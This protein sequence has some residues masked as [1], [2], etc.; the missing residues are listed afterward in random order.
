MSRLRPTSWIALIALGLVA[1]GCPRPAPEPLTGNQPPPPPSADP[2]RD[3]PTLAAPTPYLAPPTTVFE[4]SE[5]L[6]VWLVERPSLPIVALSLSVPVGSAQDPPGKGGLCHITTAM[7]DEGAGDRDAIDIS[8]EINDLGAELGAQ[9]SLDGSQVTLTVLRKH[10]ARAF[11]IFSDVVIRP[12]FDAAEYKRVSGLWLDG[13]R[14]RSDEPT[15]VARLVRAAALYGPD[16]PYGHP[17]DGYLDTAQAIDVGD[18]K[19]FH[20]ASWRPDRALL[21]AAGAVTRAELERLIAEHLGSWTKPS[22]PLP[23]SAPPPTPLQ[24]RPRLVLVDRQDAPQAV[25]SVTRPGVAAAQPDAA[26]LEL[27]NTALG[28]SFTSRLNQNL[29]ED[30]AWSYGAR[31]AFVETRG[32]GPFVAQSS[33]FTNVTAAALREMLSEIDRMA[34]SGLTE[35]E[36]RKV[37]ARD[38]T[39]TIETHETVD[40]LVSRLT[41]LGILGLPPDHDSR[42]SRVRQKA[43]LRDLARLASRYLSTK[44]ATIVVVGPAEQLLP[45]LRALDV[46][47]VER[48]SPEGRP[49]RE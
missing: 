21:V 26:L 15:T 42:A 18:I 14:S 28:G 1:A 30:H 17:T 2:L 5:G 7:L 24:G 3:K 45:Q 25:V 34:A 12:R 48:W 23:A 8:T 35:D 43:S 37:R 47:E 20:H 39:D 46:G 16:T 6:T 27:V 32:V 40:G 13:L 29:R 49:L 33:V 22:T 11:P 38:L 41:S 36:L 31:S 9:V 19:A 4:T 10:L 44:D